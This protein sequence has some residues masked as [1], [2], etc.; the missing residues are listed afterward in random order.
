MPL[1]L[2]V[3]VSHAT[4]DRRF[5]D[6]LVA[7]LRRHG[8]AVWYTMPNVVGAQQCH[9]EI[10]AALG[11]CD[12]FIVILSPHSVQSQWVRHELMYALNE[13]RYSQRIIPLLFRPCDHRALSWTLDAIQRIDFT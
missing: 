12:S 5:A 11:R 4:P 8:L 3:F 7:T 6:R 2:E 9:D 1:P 13:R 10:G